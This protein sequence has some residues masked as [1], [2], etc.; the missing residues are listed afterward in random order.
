MG[1]PPSQQQQGYPGAGYTGAGG[2]AGPFP[3]GASP[4][5]NQPQNPYGM[6]SPG[7]G[8]AYP[9][10]PM[11]YGAQSPAMAAV[12][13]AGALGSAFGGN[14]GHAVNQMAS[15]A[16][17]LLDTQGGNPNYVS[18]PIQP[19]VVH[20]RF[21]A[22]NSIAFDMQEGGGKSDNFYIHTPFKM[23]M[24]SNTG[25]NM[26]RTW[27][28]TTAYGRTPVLTLQKAAGRSW[29]ATRADGSL[30]WQLKKP[31]FGATLEVFLNDGDTIADFKIKRS[32][33]VHIPGA[34][35]TYE[36]SDVKSGRIVAT[37]NKYP[38]MSASGVVGALANADRYN[39][40]VQQ[41][42]DM[43][44]IASLGTIVD[45]EF[46][47]KRDNSASGGGHIP[48]GFSGAINNFLG[49]GSSQFGGGLPSPYGS[50]YPGRPY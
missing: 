43:V 24:T 25:G 48:G 9:N 3:A 15:Y 17:A 19:A 21:V 28:E 8:G 38:A 33:V 34:S 2:M 16:P 31:M 10:T 45:E 49:G 35:A 44:F 36:I 23:E 47:D 22:A 29:M 37:I 41:G 13:A 30:V 20:P 18:T 4:L 12:S 32:A 46:H 27:Y 7:F 39:I 50:Q 1:Y 40:Q 6:P 11:A 42:T 26:A 5:G 14:V